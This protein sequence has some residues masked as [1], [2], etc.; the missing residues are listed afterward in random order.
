MEK[1]TE[2]QEKVL[3]EAF[4]HLAE[5]LVEA[6]EKETRKKEHFEAENMLKNE[7]ED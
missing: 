7:V 4:G 3:R 5:M 6:D 1:F 2:E